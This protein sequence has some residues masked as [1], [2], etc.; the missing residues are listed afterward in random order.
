M[1]MMVVVMVVPRRKVF[2]A[3]SRSSSNR[4]GRTSKGR[5]EEEQEARESDRRTHPRNGAAHFCCWRLV[6]VS[7]S[8][9]S[10]GRGFARVVSQTKKSE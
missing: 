2:D 9:S 5:S 1:M 4:Q 3:G 6:G 8:S 7:D 10:R